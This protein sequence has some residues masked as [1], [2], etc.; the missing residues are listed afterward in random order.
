[1]ANNLTT[2]EKIVKFI[3]EN[4][5]NLRFWILIAGAV[6]IFFVAREVDSDGKSTIKDIIQAITGCSVIIALFYTIITYEYN[7]TKFKHD[8]KTSK[9]TLSFNIALEWHRPVMV[10]HLKT[11]AEF[12]QNNKTLIDQNKAHD[13]DLEL[14][15]KEHVDQKRALLSIFNYF[16]CISLGVKRG[17]MD[18]EFTKGFFKSI[19]AQFLR[20]YQFYIDYRRKKHANSGM[21]CNF[22]E[23]ACRWE[24]N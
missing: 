11:C 20:E 12:L 2:T 9:D 4:L 14:E 3:V 7:Q 21:W 6:G 18:E 1:M 10:D 15:K 5:F 16:E 19:F 23:L 17:I 8:I 22:T 24:K 13:F